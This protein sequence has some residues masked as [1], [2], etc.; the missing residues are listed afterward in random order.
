MY[1]MEEEAKDL[2]VLGAIKN[3]ARQFDKIS[4]VTKI[5]TE[6]LDGVLEKLEDRGFVSVQEKKR[7]AR[8]K[9]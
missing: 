9:N 1:F 7:M 4:K 8:K 6:E 3:G 5:K 2:I